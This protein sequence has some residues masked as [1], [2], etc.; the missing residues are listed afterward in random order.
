M[1]RNMNKNASTIDAKTMTTATT[2]EW[3]TG[4]GQAVQFDI[5]ARY[6]L[7]SQG[8]EKTHGRKEVDVT[9]AVAGQIQ[10]G[11]ALE[12]TTHPVAVAKFGI[13]GLT[14]ANY[15]RVATAIAT[16][17]DSI[18]EHNAACDAHES[19]LDDVTTDG[20]RIATA[21]ACGE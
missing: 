5:V 11:G 12:L 8:R 3:T 13:I 19:T 10:F 9:A 6:E 16:A 2:I 17:E 1:N 15:D 21:M 7:D 20:D 14:Q 4:N 18:R